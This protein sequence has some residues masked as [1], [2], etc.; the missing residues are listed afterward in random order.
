MAKGICRAPPRAQNFG[1]KTKPTTYAAIT[2]ERKPKSD[3]APEWVVTQFPREM[4]FA[5]M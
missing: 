2:L 1:Q 4:A 5:P 3:V